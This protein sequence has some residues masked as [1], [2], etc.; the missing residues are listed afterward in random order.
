MF[1]AAP[2][3]QYI[4][5]SKP[6]SNTSNSSRATLI[7]LMGCGAWKGSSL[8]YT[9]ITQSSSQLL[10]PAL[11]RVRMSRSTLPYIRLMSLTGIN[12]EDTCLISESSYS[13]WCPELQSLLRLDAPRSNKTPRG[14]RLCQM[15]M[16]PYSR[17]Y[18]VL[19]KAVTK[20]M[21]SG[22]TKSVQVQRWFIRTR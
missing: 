3:A 12:L 17:N 20:A 10:L 13:S 5:T 4:T 6:A 1:R 9:H 14:Q 16:T 7:L 18:I 21:V 8:S 2:A 22:L 11:H 15:I 19:T